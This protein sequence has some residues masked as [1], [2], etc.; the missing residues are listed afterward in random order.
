MASQSLAKRFYRL[1]SFRLLAVLAGAV[2]GSMA[3]AQS[4]SAPAIA[5]LADRGPEITDK[6]VNTA[7]LLRQDDVTAVTQVVLRERQ[8]RDRGRWNQMMSTY[9]PD[10]RVD[11]TWYHGDGPGFVYGSRQQWERGSKPIHRM[12]APAVEINGIKAYVEAPTESFSRHTVD[13]KQALITSAMRLNYRLE[14]RKGQ[15]RILSMI[16]VYEHSSLIPVV[17]GEIISIPQAELSRFRPSY[18]VL[19]YVLGKRGLTV[20]PDE[21][22]DDRPEALE[23]HY[24]AV[25]E[26]LDK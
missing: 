2:S 7:Y 15:W 22:G 20:S 13:D 23:R 21:L 17:P 4:A 25:R 5:R 19:S 11:L 26:W 9:W 18:A 24:A 14:K 12:F 6:G 8:A 1:Q 16:P 3:G 10:S